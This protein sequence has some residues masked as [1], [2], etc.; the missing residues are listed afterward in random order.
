[1][2]T[3]PPER[4][5]SALERIEE[6]PPTQPKPETAHRRKILSISL[7]SSAQAAQ[8]RVVGVCGEPSPAS[9][10]FDW[11]K[12]TK[13]DYLFCYGR[14]NWIRAEHVADRDTLS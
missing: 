13:R 3:F 6:A 1:M 8:D 12:Q 7:N 9:N 2:I 11:T 10:E 5:M 4:V 14:Q